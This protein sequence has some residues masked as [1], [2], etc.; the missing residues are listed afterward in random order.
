M[1]GVSVSVCRSLGVCFCVHSVCVYR[2]SVCVYL[3][4]SVGVCECV[5]VCVCLCGCVGTCVLSV[6]GV[7]MCVCICV[8]CSRVRKAE[9]GEEESP[10]AQT[11]QA[12]RNAREAAPLM[13]V[14][15]GQEELGGWIKHLDLGWQPGREQGCRLL[16][17]EDA[18]SHSVSTNQTN[19]D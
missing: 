3:S 11:K 4:V 1:D 12:G 14:Q 6:G 8:H 18:R 19:G 10:T 2:V 13:A 17:Q 7:C 15:H 16:S 9:C 5:C